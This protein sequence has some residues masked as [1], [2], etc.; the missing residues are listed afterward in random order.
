MLRV[1]AFNGQSQ[2]GPGARPPRVGPATW[3]P[4]MGLSNIRTGVSTS[5]PSFHPEL[6]RPGERGAGCIRSDGDSDGREARA[7]PPAGPRGFQRLAGSFRALCWHSGGDL[8]VLGISQTRSL[9][10]SQPHTT[11]QGPLGISEGPG[12]PV[13]RFLLIGLVNSC[14]NDYVQG[15]SKN[16]TQLGVRCAEI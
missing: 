7:S 4:R 1:Q 6:L 2:G 11:G 3:G 9:W 10:R 12:V 8:P 15:L 14:K 5:I 13:S 16:H